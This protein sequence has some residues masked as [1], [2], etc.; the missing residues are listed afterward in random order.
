MIV[1]LFPLVRQSAT[2]PRLI[3]YIQQTL[4]AAR[5][6]MSNHNPVHVI[7]SRCSS[8]VALVLQCFKLP[9]SDDLQ[10]YIYVRLVTN[11]AKKEVALLTK[12]EY[13]EPR[14][15]PKM[16]IENRLGINFSNK[17]AIGDGSRDSKLG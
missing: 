5:T 12:K 3:K 11:K 15:T 8:I 16:R 17:R 7:W 2:F 13:Q 1:A 4:S 6:K 14:G 9:I 10:S